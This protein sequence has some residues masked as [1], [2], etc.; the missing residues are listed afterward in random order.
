[1]QGVLLLAHGAPE[2]VED[3]AEYLSH[4]RGGQPVSP[5][6]LEEVRSRYA[7]IGGSSPLTKWTRAQAEAL[8]ASLGIPVFFGMRNWHP[9]V[10]E[11][12]EQARAGGIERL[13]CICLAPQFSEMSIGIYMKHAQAAAEGIALVWAHSYH[14]EPALLAAFA[15]RLAGVSGRVLFTAHS[16]P[17]PNERYEREARA[18][19]AGIARTAG[20]ADWDFAFQSQ[21]MSGGEWLGPTVESCL[22]RYAAG[23]VREV[24]LQPVGF[25]CDHVE[26]LYDVDI[27]FRE[28]AA[29]R[30]ITLR[31][32]ESLNGSPEFTAALA[33]VARKC[34]Q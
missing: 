14:E 31:R 30:G 23:G 16:L 18:T 10:K 21:G 19:A 3:V 24:T 2:R 1:M 4:V 33:E 5:R 13:A 8:Q 32:P 7:A 25:V 15:E 9:F 6:V 34:L 27:H 12:M 20:I 22:D 28:Y 17:A 26:I 29:A 11:S